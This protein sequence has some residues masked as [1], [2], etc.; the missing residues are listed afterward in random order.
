MFT[1]QIIT[2]KDTLPLTPLKILCLALNTFIPLFLPLADTVL[3]VLF[4]H[5]DN[6]SS[7]VTHFKKFRHSLHILSIPPSYEGHL[8]TATSP[9]FSHPVSSRT[10]QKEDVR[11]ETA[12]RICN[13]SCHQCPDLSVL[14]RKLVQNCRAD[15]RNAKNTVSPT[16]SATM[17]SANYGSK[18][19]TKNLYRTRILF[20]LSLFATHCN[21]A[22]ISISIRI[23]CYKQPRDGLEYTGECA[24]A[25]A[26]K[27][28]E[29]L[30]VWK[31]SWNSSPT[32]CNCNP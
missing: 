12:G 26:Y 10:K 15:L 18:V 28:F 7:T 31:G 22:S 3:E 2:I 8:T 11:W 30:G 16:H 1:L 25:I 19:F 20:F 17:D 14:R 5:N 13:L 32:D 21:I 24:Q 27:R 29:H 4:H 6:L 23:R 9:I